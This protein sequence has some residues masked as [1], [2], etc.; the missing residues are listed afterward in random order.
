M[1]RGQIYKVLTKICSGIGWI[2]A[3]IKFWAEFKEWEY[4]NDQQVKIIDIPEDVK[5]FLYYNRKGEYLRINV[6]YW[7]MKDG[8]YDWN[9]ENVFDIDLSKEKIQRLATKTEEK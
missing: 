5:V 1:N 3:K 9:R 6:N 2:G 7:P 8:H 4:W